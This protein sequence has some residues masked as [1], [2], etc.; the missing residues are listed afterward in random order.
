MCI[1]ILTPFPR[2]VK[3]FSCE[4]EC[5]CTITILTNAKLFPLYT[6]LTTTKITAAY[7]V[8]I[9]TYLCIFADVYTYTPLHEARKV[10]C[11]SA[12]LQF[13]R[14]VTG[15]F[16]RLDQVLCLA[17]D[18]GGLAALQIHRD[19]RHAADSPQGLIHMSLTVGAHH[20]GDF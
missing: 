2:I 19:L 4:R 5:L 7:F 15:V 14:L 9:F 17:S 12:I 11:I 6:L 16:D 3:H 1:N 8:Y 13:L 18:N 10:G 20:A